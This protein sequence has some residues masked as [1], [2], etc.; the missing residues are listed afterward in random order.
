MCSTPRAT[1]AT[2]AALAAAARVSASSVL[3]LV[4]AGAAVTA[5]L[6]PGGP[7]LVHPAA[8]G[9]LLH[10]N[11]FL[12][13]T[14]RPATARAST[15]RAPTAGWTTSGAAGRSG[16]RATARPRSPRCA[17]MRA[18]T[19]PSAATPTRRPRPAIAGRRSR[20]SRSTRRT[21]TLA[22]RA[23]G[24]CAAGDPWWSPDRL[25]APSGD[26]ADGRVPRT[27]PSRSRRS[28]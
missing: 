2:R 16:R 10:A 11:H 25:R 17:A 12:A 5:E 28:T 3:T 14:P 23:G 21:A 19:T 24:P 20:P 26:R 13:P 1:S 22:V 4:G 27:R 6:H 15:T 9:M 18:G 7:G 8:D